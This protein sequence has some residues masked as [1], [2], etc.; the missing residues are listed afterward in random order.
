MTNTTANVVVRD[1]RTGVFIRDGV[2]PVAS[3][4]PSKPPSG[5]SAVPNKKK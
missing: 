5:G 2:R 1:P 4:K 3:A